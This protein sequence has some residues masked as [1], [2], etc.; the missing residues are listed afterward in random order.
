[1]TANPNNPKELAFFDLDNDP[2]K[3]SDSSV[4]GIIS[5]IESKQKDY[6]IISVK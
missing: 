2:Q 4:S 5:L 6:K 1:L 3:Y